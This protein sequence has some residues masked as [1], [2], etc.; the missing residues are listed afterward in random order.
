MPVLRLALDRS[1]RTIDADG[2]MHI[3]R[4]HI[5]K[6][7]INPYYG[8]EIPNFEELGLKENQVYKLFRDP[9][10]LE[11]GANSF[12]RLPILNEHLPITVDNMA[13]DDELKKLIVGSIGSKITFN[14]PYLDADLC[15]WDAA[16]I[17]GIE[18]KKVC[19]LSCAY[20][21]I[22]IMEPGEFEGE[23]YDGR[24]TE[25]QG[26]HLALVETGR[27]G[28]DVVVSDHNPFKKAV[29]M[30]MTKIGK[31][32]FAGICGMSATLAADAAVPA[33]V[34]NAKRGKGFDAKAMKAALIALD[35]ELDPGQLDAVVDSVLDID[36][37]PKAVTKAMPAADESPAD[38]VRAML[39]GKVDDDVI[40]AICALFPEAAP[41]AIDADPNAPAGGLV[42][43]ADMTKAM[44]SLKGSLLEARQA[45]RDVAPV[46]GEVIGMDSAADIYGFALDHMK[47]D[48][49]GVEGAAA[50]RA[51]Y[52]VAAKA[53][54]AAANALPVIAADSASA[55]ER[56]PGVARFG[57]A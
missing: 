18:T 57:R 15:V 40:E 33:L 56:F 50:L 49:K 38:Q 29:K 9:V 34:A 52:L 4:S 1:A 10:E 55:I 45:E 32:I 19:E 28:S 7:T 5:S 23:K 24:M 39:L 6:A 41:A 47:T 13:D 51:L 44:D 17:T 21:Y 36:S 42:K 35:G 27:A 37:E 2:R 43:A 30:K 3:E 53:H 22:P 20:R 11:R 14:A 26:N 54:T 46:V 48:R 12:A 31:A 25:I 8:K 16:A